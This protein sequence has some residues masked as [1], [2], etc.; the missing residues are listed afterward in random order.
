[1]SSVFGG[2]FAILLIPLF[3]HT[4]MTYILPIVNHTNL[5]GPSV[6]HWVGSQPTPNSAVNREELLVQ[7]WELKMWC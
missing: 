7:S 5:T 1:M 4:N 6:E 3:S 2:D